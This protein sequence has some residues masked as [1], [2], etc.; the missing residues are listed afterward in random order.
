MTR[1]RR[2]ERRRAVLGAAA[3]VFAAHS[4]AGTTTAEI[5]REA[6]VSEPI[7]YRHFASKRELYLACVEDDWC[8]LRTAIEAEVADEPD[9][10]EWPLA[11][12][13]SVSRLEEQ[14]TLLAHFWVQALSE[15]GGDPVIRRHM[16]RHV[17]EVH[18][19][20]RDLIVRA[21][22]A[23]GVPPDRDP[24]AEAWIT[25]G[26]GLLRSAGE[27]LGDLPGARDFEAIARARRR[28]L[29]GVGAPDA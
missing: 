23:G 13:R 28:A 11:V 21:Q 2:E 4:F 6:Q 19:F 24:D 15:A 1:L 25:I 27:R 20:F 3:R 26:I 7:L 17:R 29:T 8:R 18:R 14:R 16:R 22:A 10:A 9:P 5:A 12:A